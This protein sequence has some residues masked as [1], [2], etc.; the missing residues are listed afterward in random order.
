MGLKFKMTL[1]FAQGLKNLDQMERAGNSARPLIPRN[2]PKP[3]VW[4]LPLPS[5]VCVNV[6]TPNSKEIKLM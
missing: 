2:V 3:Y 6:A 5:D 1:N 4:V